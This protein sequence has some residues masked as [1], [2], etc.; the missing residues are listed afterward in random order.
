MNLPFFPAVVIYQVG[1]TGGSTIRATLEKE[2]IRC[3]HTHVLVRENMQP[4]DGKWQ[5]I[6][7]GWIVR[8]ALD[9][10]RGQVRWKVITAIRE[11]ISQRI[12]DLFEN[13][14][15]HFPDYD[16]LPFHE[17]LST[18]R[19]KVSEQ[20][21][22]IN[23][24][25]PWVTAWFRL[26][27]E[28]VFEFDIF[29]HGFDVEKGYSIYTSPETDILCYRLENLRRDCVQALQEFFSPKISFTVENRNSANEKD[30]N[31]V[32]QE[33]V[34]GLKL[35]RSFLKELYSNPDLSYFYSEEELQSFTNRWS[36]EG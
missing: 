35:S 6:T 15:I 27:L 2:G 7:E 33:V 8:H 4:D 26:N 12:S 11:P 36:D 9:E 30:Y 31:R 19:T 22:E 16:Q 29:S 32:Y 13:V 28:P 18:M 20:V 21:N 10:L 3:L 34:N 23:V 25:T 5:H 17:Q 1:K 14:N 24:R